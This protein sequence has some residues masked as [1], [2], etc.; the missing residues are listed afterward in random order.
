V[1]GG[2]IF[3]SSD[4]NGAYPATD[5]IRPHDLT[6]TIYHLLGIPHDSVFHDRT[7]RPHPITKGEPLYRLL[8]DRPATDLRCQ[9]TADE[10]FVPPYSSSPLVD[11]DFSSGTLLPGMPPT[12]RRGWRVSTKSGKSGLVISAESGPRTH[13]RLGLETSSDQSIG[14]VA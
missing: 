4:R 5:P 11:T 8:G 13:V 7:N 10:R 6:A 2:Q 12:Q 14:F 1:S 3:G 9:S